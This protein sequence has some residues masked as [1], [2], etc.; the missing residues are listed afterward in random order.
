VEVKS[1]L[2]V[3]FFYQLGSGRTSWSLKKTKVETTGTL[4]GTLRRRSLPE[5]LVE[6]FSFIKPRMCFVRS[7]QRRALCTGSRCVFHFDVISRDLNSVCVDIPELAVDRERHFKQMEVVTEK[8][9]MPQRK[10]EANNRRNIVELFSPLGARDEKFED[11][12]KEGD[13]FEID[14]FDS[15]RFEDEELDIPPP[16]ALFELKSPSEELP[17]PPPLEDLPQEMKNDEAV[18]PANEVKDDFESKPARKIRPLK[19]RQNMAMSEVSRRGSDPFSVLPTVTASKELP[20]QSPWQ[21]VWSD[22]H[23][24]EYFWNNETN[25]VS[26]QKPA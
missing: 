18:K 15:K 17:G 26:W 8:Q 12:F 5:K 21:S 20:K 2:G 23:Q 25:E 9:F 22:E 7:C 1:D 13:E 4:M 3:Q 16:P 10:K 19:T 14:T 6:S 11:G 24:A